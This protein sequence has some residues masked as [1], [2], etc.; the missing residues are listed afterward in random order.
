MDSEESYPYEGRD[1]QCRFNAQTIAASIKDYS[2][3]QAGNE[4]ALTYIIATVGP[5]PVAIDASR[6]SFQFYT[7]GV[8][9]DPD[10]SSTQV[11]HLVL[12]IGYGFTPKAQ[13]FYVVKN[14]W[15][16]EWGEK[17]YVRMS[18]YRDNN[19]GIASFASYPIL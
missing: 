17:G 1:G 12:I 13:Q 7:S 2:D 14:S 3:V 10:C 4:T 19:C 16:A 6:S 11:D 5:I 8:Y 15:G 9:Y 18:R